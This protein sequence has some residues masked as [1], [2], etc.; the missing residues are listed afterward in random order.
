MKSILIFFIAIVVPLASFCQLK[1]LEGRQTKSDRIRFGIKA[2]VAIAKA[3]IEYS[4]ATSPGNAEPKSKRGAMSGVFARMVL[5]PKAL[6]QSELLM[7]GK[8]AKEINQYYSYR[9]HLTYLEL[10]LNVLYKTSDSK[11]SFFI[12]GGPAPAFYIGENIF[13]GSNQ[14][15]KKFDFGINIL[16]G[17]ELP[18]GFSINLNYTYGLVNINRNNLDGPL[19]KNRSFGLTVGYVF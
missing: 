6:F 11:G 16:T 4:P 9:T 1:N 7:V 5:G 15:F 17:Y 12:G 10:P 8:G 14:G 2:G 18:I 13:Y 19:T 3:K